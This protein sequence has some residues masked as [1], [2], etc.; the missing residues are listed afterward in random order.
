MT[1]ALAV[2]EADPRIFRYSWFTGR[3]TGSPAI[4]VLGGDAGTLTALGQSYVTLPQ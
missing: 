3:S 4:S 1:E 2:L